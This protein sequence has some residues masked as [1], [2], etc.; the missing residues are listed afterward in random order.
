MPIR[1][2]EKLN[3]R[4]QKQDTTRILV[5][6]AT[7]LDEYVKTLHF[8]DAA[9][10]DQD[11]FEIWIRPHPVYSLEKAI[12]I[13]GQP[14][15]R[16]YKADQESL[17]ESYAWADVLVYVHSMVSAEG[18]MHGVPLVRIDVENP[19]NP[20]PLMDFQDFKWEA[21]EPSQFSTTIE[22]ISRLPDEEYAERQ[23]KGRVFAERFMRKTTDEELEKFLSCGLSK[24]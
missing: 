8:L 22:Q 14:S 3:K 13:A 21:F 23:K 20:D 19:L 6:L 7:D 11:P 18:L 15:F 5:A 24:N 17:A 12:A 1:V 4:R 10:K 2:E 16:F 9:V